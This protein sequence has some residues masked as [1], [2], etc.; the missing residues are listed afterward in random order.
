MNSK[1]TSH[2]IQSVVRAAHILQMVAES[3]VPLTLQQIMVEMDLNRTTTWRLLQTLE[4]LNYV[5]RNP[6]TKSY[7]LG[8]APYLLLTKEQPFEPLIRRSRPFLEQLR[9]DINETVLLSIPKRAGTL[10][11]DQ[12]DAPHS[13]R[14][15]NYVNQLLPSHCTSNG[16]LVLSR[17]DEEELEYALQNPLKKVTPYTITDPHDMKR[18]LEWIR[19][20]GFSV[21]LREWDETENGCSVPI[22]D[23]EDK[24]VGYISILGPHH[25]L[26]KERLLALSEKM[27]HTAAE[28]S[29]QWA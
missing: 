25:R 26:T 19:H 1:K 9:D 11:I 3:P 10:T 18:E 2:S 13:I 29:S 28:I 22:L 7:E 24:A 14:P 5:E 8:H 27:K 6:V 12:I 4:E 23:S 15:I 21:S 17:M 16:K 20:Q